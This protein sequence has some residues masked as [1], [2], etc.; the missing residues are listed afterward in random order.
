MHSS[1][2]TDISYLNIIISNKHIQESKLFRKNTKVSLPCTARTTQFTYLKEGNRQRS[3]TVSPVVFGW[4]EQDWGKVKVQDDCYGG[5]LPEAW[6]SRGRTCPFRKVWKCPAGI[7][8]TLSHQ[9]CCQYPTR[10]NQTMFQLAMSALYYTPYTC[11]M[12]CLTT[13]SPI[14]HVSNV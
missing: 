1:H 6:R 9:E 7:V 10:T 5:S 8:L 2:Y 13:S 11:T 3:A 12:L 4:A 14:L